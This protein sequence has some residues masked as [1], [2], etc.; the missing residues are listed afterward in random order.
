MNAAPVLELDDVSAAHEGVAGTHVVLSRLSLRVGAHDLLA[1]V[2]ESGCGKT[3]LLRV[4]AGLHRPSAGG[5]TL[6][7]APV[8]RPDPAV[9]LVFQDYATTLL[10]WRTAL[11]NVLFGP[12]ANGT[13]ARERLRAAARELLDLMKLDGA[14][15]RYPWEL[16]GGMQQRVAIARALLR[17]PAALLLDEPWSALDEET[18]ASLHELLLRI[19]RERPCAIV[20]VSHDLENV[21]RLARRVLVLRGRPAHAEELRAGEMLTGDELRAQLAAAGSAR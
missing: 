19:H 4:M 20:L 2:G 3:T 10:P 9:A 8:L 1:V 5:V 18:R 12:A 17:E 11:E 14:G 13:A 7:G 21:V 16:S 15:E 6:K